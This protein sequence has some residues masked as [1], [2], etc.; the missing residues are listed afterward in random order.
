[1][2]CAFIDSRNDCQYMAEGQAYLPEDVS[3]MP[4]E[5]ETDV[6]VGSYEDEDYEMR[7]RLTLDQYARIHFG[8]SKT[9]DGRY[10]RY[11]DPDAPFEAVGISESFLEADGRRTFGCVADSRSSDRWPDFRAVADES[12]FRLLD[13][14][15]PEERRAELEAIVRRR[16]FPHGFM[17]AYEVRLRE[18]PEDAAE[19]DTGSVSDGYH[20]FDE[21]YAHRSSLFAVLCSLLKDRS[22]KSRLHSDGTMFD[23]MF[24]AGVD[25]PDGQAT[26]HCE[27]AWWGSFDCPELERAPEFDWHTPEDVLERLPSLTSLYSGEIDV[28]ALAKLADAL[29]R[30]DPRGDRSTFAAEEAL[31]EAAGIE[32]RCRPN[33]T[34]ATVDAARNIGRRIVEALPQQLVDFDA[35]DAMWSL[36][37]EKAYREDVAD[38][39]R[40]IADE[41]EEGLR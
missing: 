20:T 7:R 1:M 18:D 2:L 14:E 19:K 9:P 5:D 16:G 40:S 32:W 35:L 4:F 21:L 12:S 41:I 22:W 6:V 26:Y 17:W 31:C 11:K 33:M 8:C 34:V 27:D 38:L 39:L 10:G 15:T 23:G 28:D 13:G 29:L 3:G 37:H 24:V 25:T 36:E 30:V